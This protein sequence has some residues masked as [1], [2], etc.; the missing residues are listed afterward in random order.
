MLENDSGGQ[1]L[2]VASWNNLLAPE[3]RLGRMVVRGVDGS[4]GSDW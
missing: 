3:L 1:S 2:Y 4:E